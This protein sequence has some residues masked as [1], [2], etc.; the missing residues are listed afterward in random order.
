MVAAGKADPRK[1]WPEYFAP[2]DS[3]A[4]FPSREADMSSFTW[5][6][7]TPESVAS[8]LEAM[9][10]GARVTVA[11]PAAPPTEPPRIAMP[12]PPREPEVSLRPGRRPGQQDTDP[13]ALEWG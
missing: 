5:E 7:P 3:Q 12:P 8:D 4:A 10:H 11:D 9:M 1:A 6:K 13:S 2:P